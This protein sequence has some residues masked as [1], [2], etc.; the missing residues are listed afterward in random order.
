MKKTA[1]QFLVFLMVFLFLAAEGTAR[2]YFFRLHRDVHYLTT[3][4]GGLPG[5]WAR[6]PIDE[7]G[8]PAGKTTWQPDTC[9]GRVVPVT[10]NSIGR[11]GREWPLQNTPGTL[12]IMVVGASSTFGADSPDEATWPVLLEQA[13]NR[14]PGIRV[15][16]LNAS[17]PG[18]RIGWLLRQFEHHWASYHPDIVLYYEGWNDTPLEGRSAEV[19]DTVGQFH[20]DS[21]WGSKLHALYY[22]SMLYTYGVEK[23]HFELAQRHKEGVVPRISYF[24]GQI[25]RFV[26]D[27]KKTGAVPMLVLQVN[28][29]IPAP[30]LP[31]IPLNDPKTVRSF[32][33]ET[34]RRDPRADFNPET[35]KRFLQAQILVETA[36]RTAESMGV[37]IL[38]PRTTFVHY[39]S[40]S[41]LFCGPIHLTD[42][43]N[44]LLAETVAEFLW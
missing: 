12:R 11:R 14:R 3:P 5:P 43:G 23:I 9:T 39:R 17:R 24:Q 37:R 2:F 6:L 28:H 35:K 15:E 4:L 10:V 25:Q 20:A 8:F 27:V 41:P 16:V 29:S 30:K 26:Q 21:G 18:V 13:L 38:D 34:A 40:E 31:T 33:E 22:R 7:T 19:D 42:L 36:R 32:I 44:R 1:A